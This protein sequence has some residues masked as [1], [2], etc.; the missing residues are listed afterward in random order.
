[1]RRSPGG[2]IPR[3]RRSRPDEPPSSATVTT[4]VGSSP[5]CRSALRVTARPCPPPMAVTRG[6]PL[7]GGSLPLYV[8]VGDVDAVAFSA[9]PG[10]QLL[11][12]GDAAV[13]AAGAADR[14]GQVL[15]AFLDEP[16]QADVEQ[17][18]DLLHVAGGVLLGE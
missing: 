18:A 11:G 13:L 5:S 14:D 15:L 16:G 2:S 1:M 8:S 17:V 7:T 10:R 9:Q 3:S 4:A 6:A 12:E